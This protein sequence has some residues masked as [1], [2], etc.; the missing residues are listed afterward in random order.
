MTVEA[1]KAL[2]ATYFETIWNQGRYEEEPRFVDQDVIVHAPPMPGIPDGIDGPLRIV[3]TFR[4]ALP[5]LHLV[6]DHL[7]AE[8][9]R[10]VQHWTARG[11]HTGEP[12]F[13]APPSGET[14]AMT[15][16]NEFRLENGRI[17]ERWGVMDAA[18]LM[19]QLG[20]VPA[21]A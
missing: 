19:R 3:K 5:D 17:V 4:A 1:N 7:I 6:N 21:Q 16:I 2:V 14:L 18:G 15:G 10:V 8:G 12:L 11:T 20:L 13:G 9:D